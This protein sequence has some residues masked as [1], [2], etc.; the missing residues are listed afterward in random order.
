MYIVYMYVYI[1]FDL[2]IFAVQYTEK[3]Q[4]FTSIKHYKQR[5]QKRNISH[6]H[7]T[8]FK[9]KSVYI[10]LQHCQK[11]NRAQINITDMWSSDIKH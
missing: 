2:Y 10:T 4:H 3:Q 1:W 9:K 7:K 5:K 6:G 8:T 11:V